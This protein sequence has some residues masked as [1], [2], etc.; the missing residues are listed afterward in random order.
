M[1]IEIQQNDFQVIFCL[2]NGGWK[3]KILK[4]IPKNSKLILSK[5]MLQKNKIFNFG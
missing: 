5:E 3:M 4:K 1:V 2:G